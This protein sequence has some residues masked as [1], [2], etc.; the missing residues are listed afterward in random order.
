MAAKTNQRAPRA[1]SG[2]ADVIRKILLGFG[3]PEQDVSPRYV[4]WVEAWIRVEHGC[5]DGLSL[6]EFRAEVRTAVGCIIESSART[7]DDL[8]ASYGLV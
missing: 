8:A 7:N 6:E 4:A 3:N 1:T 5:L 2:Y